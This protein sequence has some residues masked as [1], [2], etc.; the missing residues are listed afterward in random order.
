MPNRLLLRQRW[1][2]VVSHRETHIM[3]D[4]VGAHK[5]WLGTTI[6]IIIVII[7]VVLWGGL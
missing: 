2:L 3:T 7:I 1:V 6:I 5:L 4:L